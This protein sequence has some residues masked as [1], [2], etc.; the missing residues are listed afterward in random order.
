MPAST[1]EFTYDLEKQCSQPY[2]MK[3]II[4]MKVAKDKDGEKGLSDKD[5]LEKAWVPPSA[6]ESPLSLPA[7]L[8]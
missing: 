4:C 7:L 5:F 3:G 6:P 8:T 2:R 1:K